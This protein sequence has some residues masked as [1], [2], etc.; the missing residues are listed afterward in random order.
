[1]RKLLHT[2][3]FLSFLLISLQSKAQITIG[4]VDAG[5]YGNG[6]NISVPLNFPSNVSD[7]PIGNT[8]ELYLSDATGNFAGNGIL[9]GAF[10]GFYTPS[11]NGI[12]PSGTIAGT[13]YKLRVRISNPNNSPVAAFIDV[14]GT[15]EISAQVSPTVAITQNSPVNSLSEG[16]LG[17]CTSDA[18]SNKSVNLRDNLPAASTVVI[19][20]KNLITNATTT[21]TE[22]GT[23]YTLPIPT[24]GFYLVTAT[25][26]T[27][28]NGIALK[29]VKSYTLHNT[30]LG[31]GI[32]DTGVSV[33]CINGSGGGA[34]VSYGLGSIDLNYPGTTYRVDWGDQNTDELTYAQVMATSSSVF[35]TYTETSCGRSTAPGGASSN[36]FQATIT[37]VS[38][39]CGTTKPITVYAQVLLNAVSK[40]TG[41]AIGCVNI[42]M[43][44][45]NAS[46]AGTRSDCTDQMDY[47]WYIDSDPNPVQVSSNNEP[48]TWTF[49][50]P[51]NHTVRLVASNGSSACI[52]SEFTFPVCIQLPPVPAFTLPETT[53]CLTSSVTANS[54]TSV[55]NNTCSATPIYTWSVSPSAGVNYI[56]GAANPQFTFPA[57]GTYNII[58][59]IRTAACEETTAAQTVTVNSAPQITMSDPALLC[60]KGGTFTFGPAAGPTQTMVSGTAVTLAD[61][62]TWT[63]TGPT[64]YNFVSPSGP[65]SKEPVIAFTDYGEY[66]VTLT[67]KNNCGTETKSQ[68]ISFSQSPEP[69]ITVNPTVCYNSPI[70][71][72]GAIT[73]G[74]FVSFAWTSNIA[75]TFANPSGT[76]ADQSALTTT[77][78][79]TDLNAASAIITLTVNTGIP[80]NCAVVADIKTVTIFPRNTGTNATQNICTGSTTAYSPSSTVSGSSFSWTATNAD[81]FA[82]GYSLTGIGAI[83]E[84]ITN[85]NATT[86]AVVTYTITPMANGCPGEPFTYTVTITP[87]PVINPIGD[88]TICSDLTV[89]L[90]LGANLPGTTYLWTTVVNAGDDVR[91]ST[92]DPTTPQAVTAITET[93]Y[94]NSAAQGTITYTIT[95]YSAGGCPGAP[96]TVV[97]KVDPALNDAIAGPDQDICNLTTYTLN[98]TP[99]TFGTG[100]WSLV[101]TQTNVTFDNPNQA[102]TGVNGLVGGQSYVFRWT[103]TAP[104]VCVAKIDDVTIIVNTP[105]VPGTT[106]TTD[107]AV[108]CQNTNS[109]TITLSGNTGAVIRWE[110]S[111][112]NGTTWTPTPVLNTTNTYIYTNIAVTTQFRAVVQNGQCAAATSTATLIVVTPATTIA[113][114]GAPQTLCSELTVRLD[115]QNT[116]LNPG[117][118]ARW[119]QTAGP[120]STVITNDSDPKTTVTGLVP[121]QN[122]TFTWTITGASPCGPTSSSVTITDLLPI[123]QNISSTSSVVCSGQR[124][125]LTGSIPTGG[126]GTYVYRWESSIDNGATWI[127]TPNPTGK[128]L[129]FLI[130]VTTQFRRQV[131]SS[132]CSNTSN[133]YEIIAQPPITNNTIAADQTICNGLTP[134][135][136]T[137]STPSGSDG[138]FNYQWQLSTN[139]GATWVDIVAAVGINYQPLTLNTTTLFRRVVS[140]ITCNGDQRSISAPVTITVKPD[141]KAEY[142]FTTDKACTPFVIDANNIR[143]IAYPDRNA[144]YTWFANGVQI[145]TG[146]TFPGYTIATS[147]QSVTIKLV[148]AP[149]Q[150]CEPS[151]FEHVFSTNQSV[152]ASFTQSATQGCSPLVINFVNTS[153]SLTNATFRWDFG[154]GTTSTQ[155]MPGA[156]TF[157]EDPTGKDTTYTVTLTAITTCGSTSVTSTVFVKALPRAIFSPSRTTGCS[158]MTVTFSNTSPGGTNTYYYD[159]GDGT[160]L[161]KT[162]KSPVQHTFIT[163]VVRDFVVKMVA[164]NDCGRDERSYTIRVAPNTVLP[165]LVVNANEKEGCA[166]FLVNFYNNSRGANLFKYDFGDGSTLLTRSAPEVVQHTFT[167]PGTYTIVLTASNGCSDTTTTE[168]ITVLP[169]PLAAFSADNTLGCPG[170]VVKFKNTST[171]GVSYL[172]DFGDGTT[173]TEFEPT[174]VFNADKE[175]YTISLTATNALG[176]TYTATLNQYIRIVAPPVALFNVAPSTLISIPNYTFRFEDESTNNPTIW[177]WDFGDKTTSTLQNPSHTYLDTGT[178]VVTL[179]VANQQG[180][181]TTTFKNV[182]IVGVPGYLYVPNSFMPGSETPELRTFIAK[183]SGIKSWTFSVFNKWGQTLWQTTKLDEGRPIEG[184]D[185]M[186]NGVLQPQGVYFWKIDVEFVNGTAWKGMTYDSSAP[187]KT[188]VIHLLR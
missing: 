116:T 143:A 32:T 40:I 142:T 4:T 161:T 34:A 101:S 79:P 74:T 106:S 153:T 125:T 72:Q 126:D 96:I 177:L 137:G 9:L 128:D 141:A 165:E 55:L 10:G 110:S 104:G 174:H 46:I 50:T 68:V 103:V 132:A 127:T 180:C 181:F 83:N 8:F 27:L 102:N 166:P 25:A 184:W 57:I 77:F 88:K 188:G 123:N 12:I 20:L 151:E 164:E 133:V 42:P 95:P 163:N 121:G 21:Y 51:G 170:L 138:A 14:P 60:T 105:T 28:V 157:L 155:T 19:T 136:L 84:T 63:V 130:T 17:F 41:D 11:V 33:G 66:T 43:T 148:T 76:F 36:S 62:Y 178:Y 47:N 109:G 160:L 152:A 86:N 169:Q 71:L 13:G 75:G 159:F 52:P 78:T 175:F 167:R 22:S 173:S 172:W 59:T 56:Q 112:D 119:T 6:S 44:F 24:V 30:I 53:I 122:Y 67:H 168:S 120:P 54:S 69:A 5:P 94:N 144:S 61:T 156:V 150:G 140:T 16:N 98:A 176:C 114:A 117:E 149:S 81:G 15:I 82:T 186:F 115:A 37:S 139:G 113:N 38:A 48:L 118:T 92:P 58:L 135:G 18:G 146:I 134:A 147:D 65:N 145:G 124:V 31:L 90:P 23:G 7:L 89:D 3:F 107:P 97:V 91:K 129:S 162:D 171:D 1:M 26:T 49:T 64:T 39:V 187:K 35:H 87:K 80:G 29:S 93:L 73:N 70:N 182:T 179:R 99:V 2:L 85:T 45:N 111:V 108:V 183:G 131:S 185:G 100:T 154:N 158:P